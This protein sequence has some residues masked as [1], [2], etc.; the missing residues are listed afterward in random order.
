M[1]K[2]S[3]Q[4]LAQHPRIRV[5]FIVVVAIFIF[6]VAANLLSRSSQ[7]PSYQPKSQV[8][9]SSQSNYQV[10]DNALKE[11]YQHLST[12]QT[13]DETKAAA[14]DGKSFFGS[15]F[16]HGHKVVTPVT[17][18]AFYKKN[19]SQIA[20]PKKAPTHRSTNPMSVANSVNPQQSAENQQ[21]A[22][23]NLTS[24]MNQNLEKLTV[25]WSVPQQKTVTGTLPQISSSS[26]G[27]S[28]GSMISAPMI[29]SGSILF[30]VLDTALNSDQPGTP[31][32]ATI[33]AGKYRGAKLLGAFQA[34]KDRLVIKFNTMTLKKVDHSIA[35]NAF[36]INSI[37]AQNAL[38]SSVNHHYLMRYGSLFASAFL[39][40]LGDSYG[41]YQ[42]PCEN[43]LFCYVSPN[44]LAP[45]RA[46]FKQAMVNG[47]GTAGGSVADRLAENFDT[48]PTIKVNQGSGMGI[49]FMSDVQINSSPTLA[50]STMPSPGT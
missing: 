46:G 50:S 35:I 22:V 41:N 21:Q 20:L 27:S 13:T 18:K 33:V 29:K 26:E 12:E 8:S 47:L 37:T 1:F 42:N 5:L 19:L 7:P 30:A 11:N 32:L 34:E 6:I 14:D 28:E 23:N 2:K 31:V 10:K 9:T 44:S 38:A 45:T 49:L 4:F 48:P 16:E 17:P 40:G 25:S 24:Q 43:S 39:Q 36:A 3:R 15:V